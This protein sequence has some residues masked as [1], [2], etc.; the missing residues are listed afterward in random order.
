MSTAVLFL[1]LLII[2]FQRLFFYAY[3]CLEDL[4][5]K[6]CRINLTFAIA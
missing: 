2:L 5:A 1:E 4:K 6:K 3:F